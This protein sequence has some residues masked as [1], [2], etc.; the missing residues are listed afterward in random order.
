[1]FNIQG[2]SRVLIPNPRV[3]SGG[4]RNLKGQLGSGRVGSGGFHIFTDRARSPLP[5]LAREG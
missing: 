5:D 3:G 2:I 1:M 4:S